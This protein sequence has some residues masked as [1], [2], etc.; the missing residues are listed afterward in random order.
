MICFVLRKVGKLLGLFVFS[1]P[2]LSVF[3]YLVLSFYVFLI[4]SLGLCIEWSKLDCCGV[5]VGM[6]SLLSVSLMEEQWRCCRW[7]STP[8]PLRR[9]W[10]CWSTSGATWRR[11]SW[12]YVL[13]SLH[14]FLVHL[15]LHLSHLN[16]FIS[17]SF[18]FLYW[19]SLSCL[20]LSPV[21]LYRIFVDCT[22]AK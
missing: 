19:I 8:R 13:A 3:F 22:V 18:L 21:S 9:R 5:L 2:C 15:P 6:L 11:T 20:S 4:P 14:R 12:V 16:L 1:C 7:P 17:K 10:R